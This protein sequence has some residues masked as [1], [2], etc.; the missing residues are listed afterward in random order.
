MTQDGAMWQ[1]QN[2]L[3]ILQMKLDLEEKQI[4]AAFKKLLGLRWWFGLQDSLLSSRATRS[5]VLLRWRLASE[6]KQSF[7][8]VPC[9]SSLNPKRPQT[10]HVLHISG[11]QS[12]QIRSQW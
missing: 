1:A 2:C 4:S 7:S 12:S 3:D 10:Q 5:L 6:L 8:S 9:T 11:Q